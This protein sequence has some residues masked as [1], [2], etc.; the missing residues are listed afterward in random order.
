MLNQNKQ[1]FI[2]KGN[3]EYHLGSFL[4]NMETTLISESIR[5]VTYI[6]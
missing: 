5:I 6:H 2:Y 1:Y 3:Y 4:I